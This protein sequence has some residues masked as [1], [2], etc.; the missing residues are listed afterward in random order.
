MNKEKCEF[1]VA[2]TTY[3]GHDLSAE[4]I[5]PDQSK[6]EAIVNMPPPED[7]KGVERLLGT[8]NYLAKFVP[9]MSTITEPIRLLLQKEIAFHWSNAQEKAFLQIKEILSKEPVLKFYDVTKPVTISCDA[10]KSGLGAVI[11]QDGKPV[12]FAS[13]SMTDPETRYAQ[14]EK[15]LLAVLFALERFNQYV[16]GK[17]V[18]VES[19]HRPLEFIMKKPLSAAP[20]R[21]QRMLL[22]LQKYT[23]TLKYRPGKELVVADTRSRAYLPTHSYSTEEDIACYVHTIMSNLPVSDQKM[24]EIQLETEKDETM[25][26]LKQTINEGWPENKNCIPIA[27][28][29]FWQYR[30]ELSEVNG[31]IL[32]GETI[33]IPPSMRREMLEKIHVGHMGI[34]KCRRRA[35]EIIFWPG[36]SSE[37]SDLVSKCTTCLEFKNSNQKEPMIPTPIPSRPWEIIA[38]DLFSLDSINYILAV[39]YYSRYFEVGK[40]GSDTKSKTVIAHMKSMFARHGIPVEV[41]SDNGPQYSSYEFQEFA[42]NWGFVHTTSSPHYPQS[43]GLA[44]KAVNI[45]KN[46]LKKAKEDHKDPYLGLLEYRNTPIDGIGSPA[47]LL[48]G[49]RLRTTLPATHAHLQPSIINPKT[50][51]K[52]LEKKKQQQKFYFDHGSKPLPSLNMGDT[53]RIQ[54]NG[55]WNPATVIGE[56]NTPRSYVVET[57]G[58]ATYRRNRRHLIATKEPPRC[59]NS[60]GDEFEVNPSVNQAV[61]PDTAPEQSEPVPVYNRTS[62]GREVRKPVR[63]NDYV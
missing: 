47:Q 28:R 48:M 44:E 7:K 51:Q 59:R 29:E 45:V 61:Q 41:K 25:K 57:T 11:C 13:R 9:S 56:A 55:H 58:G 16:Y 63:L 27:I 49:R 62:S 54:Q 15:E 6:V 19:D 26:Q 4:G 34:E 3:I 53:V 42:K 38:T 30:D 46:I 5:K 1:G 14:I 18:T 20:P 37:I 10:S 8:V 35:R 36:M 50:V 12:A 23:F 43:N 17:D 32:K 40:L 39:D 24:S 31:I 2:E 52:V 22:R 60:E 21:L 33:L